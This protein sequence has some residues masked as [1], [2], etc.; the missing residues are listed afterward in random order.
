MAIAGL[1]VL[2]PDGTIRNSVTDSMG[3]VL[4]TM[5]VSGSG[6]IPW[7]YPNVPGKRVVCCISNRT[8]GEGYFSYAYAYILEEG[9]GY[10]ADTG[11]IKYSVE[12]DRLPITLV[13]IVY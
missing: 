10:P 1:E 12:L 13:F 9:A 2:N 5:D 11:K 3:R 6:I 4:G 8:Q 7:P